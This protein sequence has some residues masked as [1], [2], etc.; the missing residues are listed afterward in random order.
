MPEGGR[1]HIKHGMYGRRGRDCELRLALGHLDPIGSL[2]IVYNYF[3]RSGFQKISLI[4]AAAASF[5]SN[6]GPWGFLL[7]WQYFYLWSR[8]HGISDSSEA[9]AQP[10]GT[11]SLRESRTKPRP[12]D[13]LNAL[14]KLTCHHRGLADSPSDSSSHPTFLQDQQTS[15]RAAARRADLVPE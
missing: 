9:I 13:S 15:D 3:R 4:Y 11:Y 2:C 1:G 10:S 7:F 8:A 14:P 12:I 6:F 5:A